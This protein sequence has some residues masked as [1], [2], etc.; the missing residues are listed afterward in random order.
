MHV[1]DEDDITDDGKALALSAKEKKAMAEDARARENEQAI[2]TEAI[3]EGI[4]EGLKRNRSKND[5]DD[6][7]YWEE[8]KATCKVLR[9]FKDGNYIHETTLPNV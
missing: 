2:R 9:K 7:E 6:E 4:A 1:D 5:K 8:H 3:A